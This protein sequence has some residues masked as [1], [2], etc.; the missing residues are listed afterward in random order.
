MES[1][2]LLARN[3]VKMFQDL[4]RGHHKNLHAF[5]AAATATVRISESDRG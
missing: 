4:N 5:L 2:L 1:P 3:V